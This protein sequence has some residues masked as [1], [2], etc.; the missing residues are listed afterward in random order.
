MATMSENEPS[1]LCI[2]MVHLEQINS[3]KK[4]C[5]EKHWHSSV[6]NVHKNYDFHFTKNSYNN[7]INITLELFM[8]AKN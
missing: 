4:Q 6:E 1:G 5:M 8:C 2:V 3:N 7:V